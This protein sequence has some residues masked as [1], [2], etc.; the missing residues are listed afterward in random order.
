MVVRGK[1]KDR[2]DTILLPMP[3]DDWGLEMLQDYWAFSRGIDDALRECSTRTTA[4]RRVRLIMNIRYSR[5]SRSG[6]VSIIAPRSRHDVGRCA[7]GSSRE[8]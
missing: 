5:V 7:Q 6:A 4:N 1:D 2:K 3:T 8:F